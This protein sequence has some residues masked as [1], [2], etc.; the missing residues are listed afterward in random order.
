MY[1]RADKVSDMSTVTI[2]FKAKRDDYMNGFSME[3]GYR[4]PKL[5]QS[6]VS[7]DKRDSRVQLFLQGLNNESVT[8][9]RLKKAG[10]P[11][12]AFESDP[13][14]T[15]EPIG[16]GFMAKVSIEIQV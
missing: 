4:V 1:E 2:E 11:A 14:W 10:V 16:N 13:R 12:Y 5:S 7:F 6:H 9:A 15:I 3:P 8:Q